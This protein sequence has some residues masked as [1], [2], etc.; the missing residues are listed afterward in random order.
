[1]HGIEIAWS[2][3]ILMVPWQVHY[4]FK[5]LDETLFLT[6]NIIDRFLKKQVIPRE[7]LQ[8]VGVTAMLLACKFEERRGCLT[9]IDDYTHE[10]PESYFN[11]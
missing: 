10:D 2:L 4:K 6:V 7:K 11:F 9:A 5:L 8:L 3:I 1:L